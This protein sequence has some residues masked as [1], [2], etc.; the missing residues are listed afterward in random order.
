MDA[1][2]FEVALCDAMP[3]LTRFAGRYKVD[4][5]DILQEICFRA[6]RSQHTFEQSKGE[7]V[8]WLKTILKNIVFERTRNNAGAVSVSIE[9]SV[10]RLED[11]NA[12]IQG[13]DKDV[14]QATAI[15]ASQEHRVSLTEVVAKI[16]KLSSRQQNAMHAL[17]FEE[18]DY[19]E[20]SEKLGVT[21]PQLRNTMSD[22]RK[23]LREDRSVIGRKRSR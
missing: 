18:M 8:G 7:M 14:L 17:V 11:D 22:A 6:L 13:I 16:A 9:E 23:A 3:E 4:T 2:D 20:A 19:P 1:H 10:E 15:P 5:Q 21:V 12:H